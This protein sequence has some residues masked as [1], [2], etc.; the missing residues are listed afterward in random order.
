MRNNK[1]YYT[2]YKENQYEDYQNG[3]FAYGEKVKPR[4]IRQ[5]EPT[6]QNNYLIE[7]LPPIK[8][9][10]KTYIDLYRPP[11]Y[12][13]DER[14]YDKDFRF[15][16]IYRLLNYRNPLSNNFEVEKILGTIIRQG[17]VSKNIASPEFLA[18]LK[19]TSKCLVDDGEREKLKETV[20]VCRNDANQ[21]AGCII[22]GMSGMGKSKS[23]ENTLSYYPQ[24]IRHVGNVKNKFL[25]TQIPWLKIDCSYNGSIKGLCQKIFTQID[26]LLGTEYLRKHGNE[27]IGIDSM[28]T[29]VAQLSLQYALG[30]LVIDEIQH[31]TKIKGDDS[32]N[33]FVSLMNEINLP[34]VYIG[35]YKVCKDIFGKDFRHARRA[36][37][38]IDIDW[39]LMPNDD[40]W[41]IL[42]N[43]LWNYQW[44]NNKTPLTQT[45][46]NVLYEETFGN[47]DRLI[48]LFMACQAEAIKSDIEEIT[49]DIIKKVAKKHFVLTK[50]M[51][52]ALK[53]P[54][55]TEILKYHD[56]RSPN[57]DE[58]MQY[59]KENHETKKKIKEYLASEDHKNGLKKHELRSNVIVYFSKFVDDTKRLEK[60]V[61]E[62]IKEYGTKHDEKFIL[63]K[64][65]GILYQ[66]QT[67][68][69]KTNQP[70]GIPR[71]P[72]KP[73]LSEEAINDFKN[74]NVK[75]IYDTVRTEKGA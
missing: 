29:A 9:F 58:I 65:A 23:V 16:A 5:T 51:E 62:V 73:R 11:I 45:I 7:A 52:K 74:N 40:E 66:S 14:T 17:Y 31:L 38:I 12:S 72:R 60:C 63:S 6:F 20:C 28:I 50:D 33:F 43:D 26:K 64:V 56:M 21:S 35:T 54:D 3:K 19:A 71:K 57:I 55:K 47:T 13:D 44:V 49:E 8:S 22:M 67:G 24:I 48:K 75:D 53:S 37:G 42:I 4:Y 25:F 18:R 30:V 32:L 2:N 46:K 1:R 61:D 27:R 15:Q 39:D 10:E 36:M 34:I 70:K 59:Y 41:D 68:S 69:E